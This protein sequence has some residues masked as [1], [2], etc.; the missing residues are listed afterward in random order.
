MKPSLS[1][2]TYFLLLSAAAFAAAPSA[3]SAAASHPAGLDQK[4]IHSDYND[5]NF[6][7]VTATLEGF[8]AA[9]KT[10]SFE[11]SV[12]IAKHLAVVYTANPETR[13]KGK[14]Y[15]YRLLALL[16]SAK[17][18]D[19]YVSDE[20]D[21]IFEK[22]REEFMSRQQSFGVD[23]AK[24]SVPAKS[25]SREGREAASGPVPAGPAAPAGR[26]EGNSHKTTYLVV[27]GTAVVALGIAAYFVFSANPKNTDKTYV[28]P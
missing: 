21:R 11:D 28:V 10:Y 19:M 27:G 7:K 18:V 22:V 13:E 3:P 4:K 12:F 6:E 14:Y 9:H 2:I 24:V 16:P 20:I 1:G 17:L 5:G 26:E 23:T 25:P 8:M 15:M